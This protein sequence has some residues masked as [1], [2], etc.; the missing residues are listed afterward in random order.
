MYHHPL[1]PTAKLK[2]RVGGRVFFK[3]KPSPKTTASFHQLCLGGRGRHLRSIGVTLLN[4]LN[5]YGLDL[6]GFLKKTPA[7]LEAKSV[8]VSFAIFEIGFREL[9]IQAFHTYVLAGFTLGVLH[10]HERCLTECLSC[11]SYSGYPHVSFSRA[12]HF[13][14]A[15]SK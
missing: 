11:K 14:S 12:S 13:G 3:F 2:N 5:I 4:I 10:Q 8:Y 9:L 6:H 1:P 15:R 7:W